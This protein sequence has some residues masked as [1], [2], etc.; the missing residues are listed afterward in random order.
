MTHHANFALPKQGYS[1]WWKMFSSQATSCPLEFIT[2]I[3]LYGDN[4]STE[5]RDQGLGGIQQYLRN[6][7]MFC[8]LESRSVIHLTPLFQQPELCAK[9]AIVIE[10][11]VVW[12]PWTRQLD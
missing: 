3:G 9:G 2:A 5:V 12:H 11:N 1:H 4:V 10:N 8:V 6:Q 7:N